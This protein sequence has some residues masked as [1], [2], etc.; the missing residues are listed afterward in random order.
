MVEFDLVD[1]GAVPQHLEAAVIAGAVIGARRIIEGQH[2]V[3][4]RGRGDGLLDGGVGVDR[5]GR[6]LR[7][8][9]GRI[10]GGIA[11]ELDERIAVLRREAAGGAG[12][13]LERNAVR[14]FGPA[15][16]RRID[17]PIR[18][19]EFGVALLEAAVHDQVGAV[20]IVGYA[21]HG[22]AVVLEADRL[23]DVG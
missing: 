16:D 22:R 14:T 4:A 18:A 1:H 2:V 3:L 7:R 15:G 23:R 8:L 11:V 13:H 19:G 17:A 21:G 5:I 20:L 12:L 6:A 10:A 9:M